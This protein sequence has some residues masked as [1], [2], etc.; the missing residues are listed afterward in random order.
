MASEFKGDPSPLEMADFERAATRL[1]CSVAAVQAVAKVESNGSGYLRDGRPKIL[2]ERHWFSKFTKGHH[3]R[4]HSDISWPKWGGYKGGEREYDRLKKAIAL[5]REAGLKSASWGAFQIM[6]FNHKAVG[7]GDVESFV[8][9]MVEGSGRQLDAFVAFIKHKKI[10]DE[11]RRLD[12]HG[13]ARVYNGPKYAEHDY[14]G[15]MARAYA[16]F[17]SGG[18]RTDNPHPV[19]RLSDTGQAVHHLQELLGIASD[20]D[21]GP[22]TKTAVIRFQKQQ[23]LHPDGVVGAQTWAALLSAKASKPDTQKGHKEEAENAR[24]PLR[25]G[26]KGEDVALLQKELGLTADG[27]FGPDTLAALKSFQ[28]GN[29]LKADGIVGRNTWA[30][31]LA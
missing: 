9:A 26:D 1:Q 12:W 23:S 11:L 10:D 14:H 19:L 18:A 28:Q 15:R 6:G 17:N 5:D 25:I 30:A 16:D 4:T 7:F 21:F 3:N 31:L 8:A 20:G 29:G 22:A 24:A 2:F 27:D 13:F